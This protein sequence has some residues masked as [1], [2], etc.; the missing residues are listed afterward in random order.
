MSEGLQLSG[1]MIDDVIKALAGYDAN[2]GQDAM[3]ALQYMTAIA[4]YLVA[5][6][7]GPDTE[8][9]EFLRYLN[10]LMRHVCDDRLKQ[11]RQTAQQTQ[12]ATSAGK[13]VP[14]ADPAVGIWKPE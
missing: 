11:H 3:I 8:R 5:D 7:P 6:F 9:E 2:A 14:T 10:D 1:A 13:S 12:P 4:G